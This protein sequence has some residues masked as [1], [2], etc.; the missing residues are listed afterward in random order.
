MT[1]Y[2]Q[3]TK[4]PSPNTIERDFDTLIKSYTSNTAKKIISYEELV[5][6]PFS[7]LPL[8]NKKNATEYSLDRESKQTLS[9]EIFL[10][11]LTEY[12]LQINPTGTTIEANKIQYQENLI[13]YKI[14]HSHY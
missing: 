11:C 1:K 3:D 4:L 6:C 2:Y 12:W 7:E 9:N 8:I 13:R 5:E 10:Y 14:D